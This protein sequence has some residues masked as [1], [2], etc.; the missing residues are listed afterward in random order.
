MCE[1]HDYYDACIVRQSGIRLPPEVADGTVSTDRKCINCK[2]FRTFEGACDIHPGEKKNEDSCFDFERY[3]SEAGEVTDD[4]K[5]YT[6]TRNHMGRCSLY[7]DGEKI[8]T[9]YAEV[10]FKC[11]N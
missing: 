4:W 6:F 5:T 9:W 10:E 7:C 1:P 8:A 11:P 3:S 2:H